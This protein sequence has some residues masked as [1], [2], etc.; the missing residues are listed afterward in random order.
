MSSGPVTLMILPALMGLV[1][2]IALLH[3]WLWLGRRR[4]FLPLWVAAWCGVT[5]MFVAGRQM[6]LTADFAGAAIAGARLSWLAALALFPVIISLGHILAGRSPALRVVLPVAALNAVLA[7]LAYTTGLFVTDDVTIRRDLVMGVDFLSPVPG[8]LPAAMAPYILVVFAYVWF[9]GIRHL[10]AAEPGERRMVRAGFTLYVVFALND[11]LYAARILPTARVFDLGFVVVA[12]GLAHLFIRRH[13]RLQAHLED[14]VGERTRQLDALVRAGQTLMEGLDREATLQRIVEEAKRITETPH[15][16]L[17]LVDRDA[18]VIRLAAGASGALPSGFQ[19]PLGQGYAGAIAVTGEP[20]FVPDAAND[21]RNVIADRDRAAG[22]RTYLGLPVKKGSEV[23]GVLTVKTVVDREYAPEEI[24][25]L[26]SFASQAAM[27]ID[28][29]RLYE[30]ATRRGQRLAALAVLTEGLTATLAVDEL[31]DRVVREA[32][33]LFGSSAARLW[34]LEDNGQFLSLRASA[35]ERVPV[36]GVVRMQV[37]EGL[38]G[39]IAATRTPLVIDDL[40]KAPERR[41]AARQ[42]AEGTVAFAGVPLVLG[43]RVVGALGLGLRERRRFG[44]EELSLLQSLANHAAI[45]IENARLYRLL[46]QRGER[47]AALVRVA[48]RLTSGLELQ[49]VL[50]S[51]SSAAAE[52]FG[53][54]AGFRVVEGSELV[55]VAATPGAREVMRLERIEIGQSASG[56][57]AASG[58]PLVITDVA[59]DP[60]VL[61]RHREGAQPERTGSLMCVPVRSGARILGTLNVYGERGYRFDESAVA[62]AMSLADQAGIAIEN[63]RL[64]A[65]LKTRVERLET[66][67]R[68]NR[69]IS[70][71][72]D[73][74]QVLQ[75]IARAA[76][77][78]VEVE[79]A[80]FWLADDRTRTLDLVGFSASSPDLHAGYPVETVEFDRGLIGWVATHRRAMREPDVTADARLSPASHAWLRAHGLRSY[81][82]V[83]VVHEGELLA[84]LGLVGRRPFQLEPEDENLVQA[85]VAQAA[86]AIRN[87]SLYAAEGAA[88]RDAELALA[89]VKQLQGMLPICAYCKKIRNDRNYWESIEGYIGERSQATFS[90]GICPDCRDTVVA[91]QMEEFRRLRSQGG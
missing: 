7:V 82:G 22:I 65:A 4:D 67:T 13:N 56:R 42:R 72:L 55:R 10:S 59:A 5:L 6:Q 90:H 80:S 69:L 87:A 24:A 57:V 84:V 8:P 51:I 73:M 43:S 12:M 11:V 1:A 83:P 46:E 85:F 2:S 21:P 20:L 27:A 70:A 29:A 68:L 89:Q 3:L 31:L 77:Q 33:V 76:S 47:L 52:T 48:R 58:E 40:E 54:E 44:H 53:G 35:G 28:N 19:V 63:A 30:A 88:R 37:G 15:V 81:Y 60:S 45:A 25:Y 17:L 38:M 62:L 23:L 49:E 41:N 16:A 32:A 66:L 75:E 91:A 9:T 74:K 18:G 50:R 86:V 26:S 39:R 71:S 14:A 64:Y 78:L 61:P 34:L 79:V 36:T